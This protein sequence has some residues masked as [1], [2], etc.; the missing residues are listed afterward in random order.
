MTTTLAPAPG[1]AQT[2]Y[3]TM[4]PSPIGPLLLTSDGQ[5]LTGLHM[6]APGSGAKRSCGERSEWRASVTHSPVSRTS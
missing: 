5:A 6:S 4:V 1:A 2:T 3:Y